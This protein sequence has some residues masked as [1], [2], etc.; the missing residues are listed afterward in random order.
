MS[1]TEGHG[2]KVTR[3]LKEGK[4]TEREPFPQFVALEASCSALPWGK[5]V[6]GV[7]LTGSLHLPVHLWTHLVFVPSQA[8]P[9]MTEDGGGTRT[10]PACPRGTPLTGSVLRD[11]SLAWLSFS[12]VLC[13]V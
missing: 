4:L 11:S 3:G 13:T 1:L 5:P 9:V 10:G 2:V 8:A 6:L 7:Q 12:S